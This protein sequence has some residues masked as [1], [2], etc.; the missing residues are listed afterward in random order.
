MTQKR[1]YTINPN[2]KPGPKPKAL[3]KAK[4][5]CFVTEETTV[6]FDTT[7]KQ[8]GLSKTDAFEQALKMWITSAGGVNEVSST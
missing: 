3:P 5:I 4:T 2:N 1:R 8:R 6:A 7:V